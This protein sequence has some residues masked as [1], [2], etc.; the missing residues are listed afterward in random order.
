[1]ASVSESK[2]IL[3]ARF[4]QASERISQN[5][6]IKVTTEDKLQLYSFYKQVS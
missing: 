4:K 1:M 5:N 6:G 2:S 3:E